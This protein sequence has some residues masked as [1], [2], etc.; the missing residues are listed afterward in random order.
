MGD[1]TMKETVREKYAESAL[2][3]FAGERGT[4]GN[5]GR[6]LRLRWAGRRTRLRA[7]ARDIPGQEP[8]Q[9][10]QLRPFGDVR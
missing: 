8:P 6:G 3:V 5:G 4:C 1:A 9:H 7:K 2:R 10:A